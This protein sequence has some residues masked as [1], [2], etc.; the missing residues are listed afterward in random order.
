M[1]I[2]RARLA[3]AHG[4]GEHDSGFEKREM[5]RSSGFAGDRG[6]AF[7]SSCIINA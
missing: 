2:L 7:T 3:K 5:R 1:E 6:S 4:A